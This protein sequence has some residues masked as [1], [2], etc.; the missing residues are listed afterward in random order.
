M[1]RSWLWVPALLVMSGGCSDVRVPPED[2]LV[3]QYSEGI[4]SL[5]QPTYEDF[6]LEC[7]PEWQPRD[8][9]ARMASYEATRKGGAVTFSDDGIE[10][11][12][13]ALLGRGGY[14]KVDNA[15]R[16]KDRLQFRTIV[17]PEYIAINYIDRTE[18]PRG[19]ILFL[20]GEPIGAVVSLRPGMT[21]GPKRSV[22]QSVD[23]HWFWTRNTLGRAEW[24]L[25]SVLPIPSS[26]TFIE[27]QFQEDMTMENA[28]PGTSTP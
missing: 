1:P 22:L 8:L 28:N 10:V 16:E 27:L 19:A 7:H 9:S 26:A 24:C 4:Q 20:M 11:I 6:F 25:N 14:F 3:F 5:H 13:L 2:R 15:L 17:K 21:L 23:L 18:F 12:K